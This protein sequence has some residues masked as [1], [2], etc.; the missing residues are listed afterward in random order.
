MDVDTDAYY[1][2]AVSWAAANSIT[3]GTSETT[4]SPEESCTRG[5]AVTFLYNYAKITGQA[6]P[7]MVPPSGERPELPSGNP[8]E[9]PSG[10][11]SSAPSTNENNVSGS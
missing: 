5:Q 10:E 9:A 8:P 6:G 7:G 4:F 3:N 11:S 2:D 1:A